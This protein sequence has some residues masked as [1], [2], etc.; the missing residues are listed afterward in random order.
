META[1]ELITNLEEYQL[2]NVYGDL[3][4]HKLYYKG[5]CIYDGVFHENSLIDFTNVTQLLPNEHRYTQSEWSKTLADMYSAYYNCR[6]QHCRH[7]NFCPIELEKLD[8]TIISCDF[9]H[10]RVILDM[11]IIFGYHRGLFEWKNSDYFMVKV[12]NNCVVF[13]DWLV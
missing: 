4:N 9:H 12:H 8:D 6:P 2:R 11:F 3:N 7:L 13:K 5:Q 1:F 10:R